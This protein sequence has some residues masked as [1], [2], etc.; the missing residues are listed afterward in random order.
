M[1]ALTRLGVLD[2]KKLRIMPNLDLTGCN[3][4]APTW[5]QAQVRQDAW[6][7]LRQMMNMKR[8]KELRVLRQNLTT[9][10]I[11]TACISLRRV[12]QGI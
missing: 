12:T 11:P 9:P 3:Q 10:D 7:I 6:T 5:G 2:F 8:L 1:P 4:Y